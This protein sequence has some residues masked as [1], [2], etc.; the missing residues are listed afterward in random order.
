MEAHNPY[1]NHLFQLYL[2]GRYSEEDLDTLLA[3][4]KLDEDSEQLREL[5]EQQFEKPMPESIDQ[6][7]VSSRVARIGKELDQKINTPQEKRTFKWWYAAASIFLISLIGTF[8]YLSYKDQGLS[9]QIVSQ[10]G[11]DVQPGKNLAYITLSDGSSYELRGD[12]NEVS[13]TDKGIAYSDGSLITAT[14]NITTAVINVPN[15]GIYNIIL[16]DGTKVFLNSASKLQYPVRFTG[17]ERKVELEGEG[18]FEVVP[19]IDLP[20]IVSTG[21]QDLKVLGTHFNIKAYPNESIFSTLL[22]GRVELKTSHS[23]VQLR[24]G[25]QAE[26]VKNKFKVAEVSADDYTAWTRNQ[27]AYNNVPLREIF[28]EMERWYDVTIDYPA[29]IGNEEYFMK[30]PKDQKLSQVL[31]S[32]ASLTDIK[33]KIEGRRVIVSQ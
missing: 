14:E 22:E 32:L 4:F 30:I 19:N 24:P 18:Y 9:N 7:E 31:A 6:E 3:Y 28:K 2:E 25:Q 12:Q 8:A 20:F 26:L 1:I 13:I 17:V 27:F 16:P 23:N 15:G 11:D 33:F 21:V 5:I 29:A 10:Y